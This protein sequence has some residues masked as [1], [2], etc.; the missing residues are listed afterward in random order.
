MS[1][2]I[3]EAEEAVHEL[4]DLRQQYPHR[5][6]SSWK[7]SRN[8]DGFY[9]PA[10]GAAPVRRRYLK[11]LD[12]APYPDRPLLP[13]LKPIHDRVTVEV[14]RGCIRGC[15]FCQAGIIYRPFRERGPERVK[16]ILRESLACTGYE[17]LSLASL[18]SGDYSA[19]EP[20]IVELM[21]TYRDSRVSVSLPSLRVGTLTPAH[22]RGDRFDAQD[23]V[24]AGARG[25]H[26][27]APPG[28]QQ[29]GVR[30]GPAPGG[31]NGLHERMERSEALL[32][33]R[34]SDGD[35]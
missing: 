10:F 13:L 28:D 19:I 20:L 35:G 16:D 32:H 24:H 12:A 3:G 8:G 21:E 26:R 33:D 29:T 7:R 14:A 27:T 18:S 5:A 11:D 34:T 6:G 17:E 2:F 31:G 22:D 9:V 4:I 15:R 30:R 1:S 25:G 23:R